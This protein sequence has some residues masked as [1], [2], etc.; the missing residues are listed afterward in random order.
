MGVFP[1][2]IFRIHSGGA[3]TALALLLVIAAASGCARHTQEAGSFAAAPSA[4]PAT[5]QQPTS[6]AQKAATTSTPPEKAAD[7]KRVV[8]RSGPFRA[9]GVPFLAPNLLVYWFGDYIWNSQS[10]R[11]YYT[12]DS[13]EVLPAWSPHRCGPYQLQTVTDGRAGGGGA[14]GGADGKVIYYY[15]SAANWSLFFELP[16]TISDPCPFVQTFIERFLYFR[17]SLAQD[18]SYTSPDAVPFPA[19]LDLP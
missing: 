8:L 15:R 5:A 16:T 6:G 12:A 9:R 14:D 1:R 4:L 17:S 3:M 10:I 7:L 11:T 18:G 19:I 13:V 2:K